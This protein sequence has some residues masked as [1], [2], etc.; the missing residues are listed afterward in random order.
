MRITLALAV[1]VGAL[2]FS[3]DGAAQTSPVAGPTRAMSAKARLL[4]TD[5][6]NAYRQQHWEEAHASFL[7][8]WALVKHYTIEGNLADCELKMRQYSAA[9]KHLAHYVREMAK[10]PDSTPAERAAG[11]V[12]YA[13]ARDQVGTV[14]VH[15]NQP[16]S[17]IY[18][19]G[20][21]AG[22]EPLEDPVFLDPG[23][24]VV[25]ARS[26]GFPPARASIVVQPGLAQTVSLTL[27]LVAEP[28]RPVEALPSH[29]PSPPPPPV[30]PSG[31]RPGL[32][33]VVATG[34][35][36]A[37]GLGT[38]IG[39]TVAANGKDSDATTI[40]TRLGASTTCTSNPAGAVSADCAAVKAAVNGADSLKDAA[41]VSFIGGGVFALASG[42]LWFWSTTT[43]RANDEQKTAVHLVP[44]VSAQNIG[45]VFVGT[46]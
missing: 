6:L 20:S 44:A 22:T 28:A 3:N 4:F 1:L 39:L 40:G 27:A 2:A 29:P 30:Q 26:N 14:T 34:V 17:E 45:L 35:L 13:Q 11:N 43:P 41:L 23:N 36:A 5:G 31:T 19:D 38:G 37:A 25:E 46:W 42:G 16:G 24:H 18:V 33:W 9:A 8:A 12:L 21:P 10:D 15:A 7:A 32:G